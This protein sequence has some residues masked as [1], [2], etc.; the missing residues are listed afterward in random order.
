MEIL[1]KRLRKCTL[2]SAWAPGR[3]A[4]MQ[5]ALSW[6]MFWPKFPLIHA[7]GRSWI[8]CLKTY[9][10]VML[11]RF[12]FTWSNSHLLAP[13]LLLFYF[14]FEKH[15]SSDNFS[16]ESTIR[17]DLK[18]GR[19]LAVEFSWTSPFQDRKLWPLTPF[20]PTFTKIRPRSFEIS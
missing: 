14:S 3:A 17:P 1:A 6:G 19:S 2:P 12:S 13:I 15:R 11:E 4:K 20:E 9:I 10:F 5:F 8:F 16:S 18:S 7:I